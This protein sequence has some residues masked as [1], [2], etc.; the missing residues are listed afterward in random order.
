MKAMY[1]NLFVFLGIL[2]LFTS[3]RQEIPTVSLGLSDVYYLP[4]MKAY[5]FTPGFTGET[6]RLS[7]IQPYGRCLLYT[8]DAADEH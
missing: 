5:R 3:C 7:L 8:S 4:R 1:K 6:Y 2:S